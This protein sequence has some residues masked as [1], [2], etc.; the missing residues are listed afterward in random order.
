MVSRRRLDARG[1][2]SDWWHSISGTRIHTLTGHPV[3]LPHARE[4][5]P[6]KVA[7]EYVCFALEHV[8]QPRGFP[9]LS[10]LGD[11]EPLGLLEVDSS[12]EGL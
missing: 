8:A 6:I 3:A 5:Y 2:R 4:V 9:P 12:L 11:L 1:Q 7:S 10:Q